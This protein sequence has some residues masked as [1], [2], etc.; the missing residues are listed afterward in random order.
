MIKRIAIILLM[1]VIVLAGC[2]SAA[3]NESQGSV[4]RDF[5][6]GSPPMPVEAPS[7]ELA[8]D[9]ITAS[10]ESAASQPVE[11]MVIRNANLSIVVNDPTI[12]VEDISRMAES[13]EGFVVNSNLYQT[14]TLSGLEVPEAQITV[15][16][17][18]DLLDEAL[19]QIKAHVDDPDND[20]LYENVS[21][22]DVTQEYTD[23]NS[24]LRN[25]E[26]TAEQLREIMDDAI[27]TEDVLQ[28]FNELKNVNE[29]IEVL[30]G[31][32]QYYEQSSKLS[33]I[34]VSIK[35]KESVQPLQVGGWEPKGVAK[36]AVESLIRA[37]QTIADAVIWIVI[38]CLPIAIPVGLV[39]FFVI[40][41]IV[42]WNQKR[43]ANRSVMTS[44]KEDL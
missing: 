1:A 19:I 40:R 14:Q 8:K 44:E 27:R 12:V 23:L 32:I 36:D 35:A 3:K 31:Q 9:A 4:D 39:L 20:V 29:Q 10:E 41:G 43:K 33:A 16:V 11:R 6:E 2:A 15:R 34:T 28:V 37:Y 7:M 13:M 30:K 25:L 26:D 24:R 5:A 22:Q 38:F 18:A 21:G 42:K 17:R